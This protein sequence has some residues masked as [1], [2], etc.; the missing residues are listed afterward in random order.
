MMT[1]RSLVCLL[2]NKNGGKLQKNI[3]VCNRTR[4]EHF[5]CIQQAAK[6]NFAAVALTTPVKVKVIFIFIYYYNYNIS[7]CIFPV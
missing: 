2:E 6:L 5:A 3:F 7:I 1:S 4:N